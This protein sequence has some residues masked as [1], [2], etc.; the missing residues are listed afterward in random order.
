MS[1]YHWFIS[2]Y[3]R[4]RKSPFF[5]LIN[6]T[7]LSIGFACFVLIGLYV[8]NELG[9]DRHHAD[10][11]R[12]FRI[13]QVG[14]YSGVVENSSS[15]P[16]PV[17][18]ALQND[19]P[20]IVES[21]ARVFNYQNPSQ[22]ITTEFTST[23]D[24]G[25]FYVDPEF[26]EIFSFTVLFGTRTNLL[27]EPNTVVLTRTAAKKYFG[28]ENVLGMTL[29]VNDWQKLTVQAVLEDLPAQTHLRYTMLASMET[30]RIGYRGK[31]PDT[32]VWNPCWTYVKLH[33]GTSRME[34]ERQFPQFVN[35][36]FFDVS[37]QSNSLYL[38][39]LADIHLRSRLDYEIAQNGSLVNVL[40]FSGLAIFLLFMAIINFMNLS[41]AT[42]SNRT[43]EITIRK[44]TGA[45]REKLIAYLLFEAIL[46]SFIAMLLAL[47]LTEISLPYFNLLVGKTLYF[48]SVFSPANLLNLFLVTI[49]SGFL[50]G[51]Y[52]AIYL[53]KVS[54]INTLKG[55]LLPVSGRSIM[56]KV[57]VISQFVIG[58]T[59]VL[60][61][62]VINS[63]LSFLLNSDIGF[64]YRNVIIVP[65]R[66]RVVKENFDVLK[67][68]I[69]EIP[70]VEN[71][72]A[73]DY[74]I[75]INHNAHDFKVEGQDDNYWQYYPALIVHDNFV[76][77]FDIKII[78]GRTYDPSI[79][80]DADEGI[81]IS[82]SMVSHMGW[83]N[84]S[85]IGKHF[86]SRRGTEKVI[87][88]FRDFNAKSL[89][90]K[91]EPFVLDM[92]GTT[93][94]KN[95]S[96]QYLAIRVSDGA[97]NKVLPR[98]EKAWEELFPKNPFKYSV[99]EDEIRSQY[100]F[101][102][103]LGKISLVLTFL[104]IFI[105]TIGIIGLGSFL[106]AQR[107]KEIGI[108]IVLGARL[109]GISLMLSKEYL[110]LISV[111]LIISFIL[112]GIVA[113]AWLNTFS[114]GTSTTPLIF[115]LTALLSLLIVFVTVIIQSVNNF[116]VAPS[117]ILKT[118]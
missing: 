50:S 66:L 26:F 63:Q 81:L 93:F 41:T 33:E 84:K 86:A 59:L 112:G 107:K 24:E 14:N 9:Y 17:K 13:T 109:P 20:T 92:R 89:H 18:T 15:V 87:G 49:A 56:R 85:A 104:S 71:F 114:V 68:K 70:D 116:K 27:K 105:A 11:E 106:T 32:W 54:M 61:T 19:Y 100:Q 69:L 47:L 42:A 101:E 74:V 62:Q 43:R 113:K 94:F 58:L 16:F 1:F 23:Y 10:Y 12:I 46:V 117:E 77:T 7:G 52:P 60:G 39:P 55:N 111:A 2:V 31:L 95:I 48:S 102:S 99:L 35:K 29:I 80:N 82:E 40:I 51:L 97:I 83:T 103:Q 72:T 91:N 22:L 28:I 64:G 4:F 73:M 76:E 98:I 34:L 75:G 79:P 45:S 36:Y 118:E 8:T 96:A 108:R 25:L 90:S 115:I 21:A 88:V 5:T 57:L 78:E 30:V 110:K 44:I 37:R 3:R 6:I 67:S 38:Q 53:S 65:S